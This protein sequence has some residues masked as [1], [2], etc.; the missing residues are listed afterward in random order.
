MQIRV[1][2][3]ANKGLLHKY[4]G[5]QHATLSHFVSYGHRPVPALFPICFMT[6]HLTNF[7][8]RQIGVG[9]CMGFQQIG[10]VD[11]E[12]LLFFWV[13]AHYDFTNTWRRILVQCCEC[14]DFNSFPLRVHCGLYYA[15]N[16]FC[17]MS[18]ASSEQIGRG[19]WWFEVGDVWS[20]NG[21]PLISIK[22]NFPD[23]ST[24]KTFWDLVQ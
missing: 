3:A 9:P 12:W 13:H 5:T 1:E 21:S 20:V 6:W 18:S 24:S 10:T 22:H 4:L 8:T 19:K 7:Y 2:L 15:R 14:C 16:C 17:Q 23:A 11:T